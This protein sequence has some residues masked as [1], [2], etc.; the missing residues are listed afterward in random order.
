MSLKKKIIIAAC[1][2]ALIIA[3][4]ITAV[5]AAQ[6]YSV[7][8]T[9]SL[10]FTAVDVKGFYTTAANN[11]TGKVSFSATDTNKNQVLNYSDLVFS[12]SSDT[13]Q[14]IVRVYNQGQPMVVVFPEL[15]NTAGNLTFTLAITSD[16]GTAT[17]NNGTRTISNLKNGKYAQC[18]YTIAIAS[19]KEYTNFSNTPITTKTNGSISLAAAS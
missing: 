19:G 5:F 12:K 10:S 14:I 2:F 13:K 4:A 8:A 9:A 6:S 7:S 16:D 15:Q 1:S 11:T 17:I 18:T 3:V